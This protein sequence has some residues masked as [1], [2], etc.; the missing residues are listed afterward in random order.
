MTFGTQKKVLTCKLPEIR[1]RIEAYFNIKKVRLQYYDD[2]FDDWVD[3][4]D[5]IEDIKEIEAIK[6]NVLTDEDCGK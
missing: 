6:L 2:D 5:D 3:W 1:Q 4:G